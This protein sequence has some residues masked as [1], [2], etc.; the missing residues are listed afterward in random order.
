MAQLVLLL[1]FLLWRVAM[2]TKFLRREIMVR[3]PKFKFDQKVIGVGS[4]NDGLVGTVIGTNVSGPC[5]ETIVKICDRDG[6][7]YF[8][9]DRECVWE[10][11]A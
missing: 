2:G 8:K 5:W 1:M 11:V 3:I 9:Q 6:A 10:V 7:V 4:S